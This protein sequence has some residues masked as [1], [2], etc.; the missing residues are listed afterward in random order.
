M[1]IHQLWRTLKVFPCGKLIFSR[2]LGCIV[3]YSGSIRAVVLELDPGRIRVKMRDCR[4]VRNHLKSV[5]AIALVNLAELTSGLSVVSFL[6]R[7]SRG[8]LRRIEID[9]E[10][11]ARGL[12]VGECEF[13]LPELSIGR[14]EF[15]VPVI[16][17][18]REGQTVAEARAYWVVNKENH[19]K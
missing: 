10:K 16:L 13:K 9:Y 8:I 1:D 12:I 3:P 11:K 18:N 17:K 2:I 14:Q 19:D 15:T 7:N 4:R 5:H 6:K